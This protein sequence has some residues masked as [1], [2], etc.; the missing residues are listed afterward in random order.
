MVPLWYRTGSVHVTADGFEQ[1]FAVN[2]LAPFL[3]TALLLDR[4]KA[5]AP[6]RILTV[7][8][9]THS[10]GSIDFGDLHGER[11]YSGVGAYNQS[12]L[13]NIMFTYELARRLDGSGVTATALHPGGL[14][15]WHRAARR[16]RR[17]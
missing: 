10:L 7:A 11:K 5:S 2:H 3:L 15:S 17:Y 6:A 4:L 13:A 8:S 14:G 1:T 9:A 12:K 16:H